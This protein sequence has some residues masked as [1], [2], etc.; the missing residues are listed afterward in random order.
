MAYLFKSNI[1]NRFMVLL[2]LS[3]APCIAICIFIYLKDKHNKEPIWLLLVSFVLGMLSTIPA[4]IVQLASGISLESLAGKSYQQVAL[5]AFGV[6]AVSE[7]LS[8]YIMVR[9]FAYRRQAFDD[10][11]DGIV[12]AVMVSMGFATLENIGYVMQHGF[13]TGIFRM[14]IS[15]PAHATFGIIMGYFLGLAKFNPSY[16]NRYLFLSVI[17][18]VLFHGAFDFFLFMGNSWLHI[19]GALASFIIAI[20]L[21]KNAIRKHQA[22]SFAQ[23]NK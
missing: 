10:P 4:I 1:K 12:Y 22:N 11:F 9:Y 23:F 3:I 2:A 7:E 5:F 15:V 21:S 20:R 14:F 8:K 18:P 17:F 16:K 6:V 19:V 13:A